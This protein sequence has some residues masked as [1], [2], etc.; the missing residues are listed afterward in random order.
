MF[1]AEAGG[2]HPTPIIVKLVNQAIGGPLHNLQMKTTYPFWQKFFANFGTTPEAV[3]GPY[4]PETA[5]P[6][7]TV[8]FVIACILS[9]IIIWLLRGRLSEENQ[10]AANKHSSWVCWRSATCLKTL[11][12]HRD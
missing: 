4:T 6:W 12:V 2:E 11:L 1:F 3:F 7:Y 8:M 10:A 5:M 9:V